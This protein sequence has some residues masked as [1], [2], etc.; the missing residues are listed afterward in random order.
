MLETATPKDGTSN[1]PPRI[2]MALFNNQ[3]KK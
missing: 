2:D 1:K 3:N